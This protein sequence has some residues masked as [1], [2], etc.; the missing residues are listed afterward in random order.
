MVP[1]LDLIMLGLIIYIIVTIIILCRQHQIE[2]QLE[3]EYY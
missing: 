3:E 1:D 2:K